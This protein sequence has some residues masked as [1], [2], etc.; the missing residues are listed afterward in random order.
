MKKILAVLLAALMLLSVCS[1]ASAEDIELEFVFHKEE[2]AAINAIEAVC[3]AF[4]AA[5]PGIKVNVASIPDSATVL[6][7]RAITDDMPD[8]FGVTTSTTFDIMFE[9]GLIMDL[10]DQ[11]FLNNVEA[12]TLALSACNGKYY[13]LPYSLSVYG[14]Y[15]RTDIFEEQG[16]ELPTTWDEL[17]DVCEKL[18][19]AGITPFSLPD[20]TMVY[21]RMERMMSFLSEDDSEFKAIAAGEMDV[22]DSTVL[23]AFAD[24]SL[25][26][27][28]YMTPESLGAEYTE[29]YQQLIAGEAAMTINGQWSL[30]TLKDYDP[31]IKVALIPL[32]NPIGENKVVI[33]IDSGFCISANTKYPEECLKFLEF[34][35]Q[36]EIAQMYTD[37]E[38][39]PNTINGVVMT[40]PELSVMSESLA[41]GKV[42]VS[43]NAIWPSGFRKALGAVA[44]DDLII[45]ADKDTFF[46]DA[47]DTIIEYYNN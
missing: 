7:T 30:T 11:A 29:S 45:E 12:S 23:N 13:R 24:A 4:N 40:V 36:T 8:L 32:P 18:V 25:K 31:D 17:M 9:D 41:A 39:S 2:Q 15:V 26:I 37:I 22:K 20:K 10:S 5:N 47:Y 34:M 6:Q 35:A 28:S 3:E 33:S 44:T 42:C 21:Q 16:L 27:A 43:Q 19:A 38:G 46:A 14:L 1:F